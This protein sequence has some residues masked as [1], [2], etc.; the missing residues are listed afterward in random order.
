MATREAVS[1]NG[2]ALFTSVAFAVIGL[3]MLISGAA[4]FSSHLPVAGYGIWIFV[5][6]LAF[7]VGAVARH[8]EA[9]A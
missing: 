7:L 1:A 4:L 6:G 3:L 5:W 8:A 9:R 2:R